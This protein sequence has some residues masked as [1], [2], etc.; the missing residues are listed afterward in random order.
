M[1]HYTPVGGGGLEPLTLSPGEGSGSG[2]RGIQHH[3]PIQLPSTTF[4][5]SHITK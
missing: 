1:I 5:N 3:S 2:G 4:L